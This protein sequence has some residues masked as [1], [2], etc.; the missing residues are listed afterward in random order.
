MEDYEILVVETKTYGV[1]VE[2][3]TADD[4]LKEVEKRYNQDYSDLIENAK[5]Y[6]GTI[7]F[8]NRREKC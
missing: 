2:A 4:A 3:L 8:C 7:E 5:E 1:K 6:D